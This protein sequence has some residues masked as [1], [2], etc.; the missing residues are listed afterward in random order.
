[1]SIVCTHQEPHQGK[2]RQL[3]PVM[4]AMQ[5]VRALTAVRAAARRVTASSAAAGSLD[6]GL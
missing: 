5:S 4:T 3:S 2:M 6:A 1:M